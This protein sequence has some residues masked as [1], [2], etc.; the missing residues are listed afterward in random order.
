ML[1]TLPI[2]VITVGTLKL[3]GLTESGLAA[4]VIGLTLMFAAIWIID[5]PEMGWNRRAGK[6]HRRA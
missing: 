2:A 6:R 5:P 4:A 3:L 1:S